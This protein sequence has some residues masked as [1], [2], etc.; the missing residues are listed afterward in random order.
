MFNL[1]NSPYLYLIC[2]TE[3]LEFNL[4]DVVL[5]VSRLQA[6]FGELEDWE[7]KVSTDGT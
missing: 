2:C 6:V 7:G 4:H 5:S 3:E 1:F